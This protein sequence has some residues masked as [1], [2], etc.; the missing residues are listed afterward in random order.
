MEPPAHAGSFLRSGD[1]YD[2]FMGRYSSALAGPFADAAGVAPGTSALDVGCGPGALTQVL[3]QRLGAE[4]VLAVDP[5][6]PFVA[7][8]ASRCPG[9]RVQQGGAEAL[10]LPDASVDTVLAQLV[11]HFVGDAAAAGAEFRRVVRPGGV[12]AACV[13]DFAE[14]MEML[15]HFW[16]AA[17]TI[18]PEAPDEARV[19]RFGR[20]GELAEWLE[21]AGFVDVVETRLSV[22]STYADFDEL[23]T[24]FLHGIGPA[25]SFCVGLPERSRAALRLELRR[26]IGSPSSAFTLGARALCA[27]GRRPEQAG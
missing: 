9:V 26:R 1:A 2:A 23:W 24:G 25:G 14:E 22:S 7:E 4:N 27:V 20:D 17:L 16:D 8:C 19:L 6:P 18:D 13:W 11:L 15:R 5:S 10:P 3:V 21:E 12:A